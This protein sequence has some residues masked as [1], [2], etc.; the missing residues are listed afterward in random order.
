MTVSI[1]TTQIL[2]E[3]RYPFRTPNPADTVDTIINGL[4]EIE[5]SIDST[6]V[7]SEVTELST[8]GALFGRNTRPCLHIKLRETKTKELKTFG[9]AILPV[10][11]GNLVYLVKYE[12]MDITFFITQAERIAQIKKKLNTIDK[13]MEYTFIQTLG[14]YVYVELLKKHDPDFNDNLDAFRT[15][16]T[17]E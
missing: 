7:D 8:G 11:F 13:W 16:L 1:S 5:N 10:T 4:A 2:S 14:D 15:F 6:E 17:V 3:A 9:C 12:Y